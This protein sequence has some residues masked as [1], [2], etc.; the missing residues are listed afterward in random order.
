MQGV[1]S[2]T[3]LIG[4]CENSPEKK[5]SV[6]P[7]EPEGRWGYSLNHSDIEALLIYTI[8]RRNTHETS[9]SHK[10]TLSAKMKWNYTNKHELVPAWWATFHLCTL[11]QWTRWVTRHQR[12]TH[13]GIKRGNASVAWRHQKGERIGI[14]ANRSCTWWD[15]A[16]CLDNKWLLK[17]AGKQKKQEIPGFWT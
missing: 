7:G 6:L 17:Q 14:K 9:I 1:N 10:N 5:A 8:K 15:M 2:N 11:K 4:R 3:V 13:D 16:N 12:H